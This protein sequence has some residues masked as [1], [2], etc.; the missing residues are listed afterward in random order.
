MT[1]LKE[2]KRSTIQYIADG[3]HVIDDWSTVM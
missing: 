3:K 1:D 2:E